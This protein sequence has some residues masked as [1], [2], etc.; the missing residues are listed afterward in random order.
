MAKELFAGQRKSK[1]R[2]VISKNAISKKNLVP[3]LKNHNKTLLI[4]DDGVPSKIVREVTA[5]CKP[6]TKVFQI[7]LQHG[8]Q[9]KSVQNFQKILNFLADNNFDRTDLIV[10]VGGGVVGD[11]SGFVASSYLRGI[12]FIQIPTTL[13]AQVDSSVGGKT[14][15]NILSGKNLVGAFY[16]PKG[17]IIDTN[18][19][20]SLPNRQLKAGLAEVIKYAFIQNNALFSLLKK[21]PKKIL[22]KDHKIIEEII[23]LSLQTKARIVTKDEKENGIRAILNFGH[24]FG[25]AIEA[26]GKYKKILHGEAVAKGMRIASKISYLENL[27]SEKE[28]EEVIAL[29]QKYEFDLSVD[30]YKYRELKP[31]IFRDKKIKAGK[32][33]LIL[34]NKLSNAVVTNAFDAKNLQ[35]GLQ[36]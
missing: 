28:Y 11:I 7:I 8:E 18:V 3:L 22:S 9:A 13:L 31:Y 12:Q 15:I 6:S 5:V 20:H 14:A 10:A 25:H 27:I 1:Y 16:N 19:L 24:T 29:L 23:F 2:I 33:N 30:Q 26:H 36:D 35:K 17:V 21:Y 4:S 34:L 32:L